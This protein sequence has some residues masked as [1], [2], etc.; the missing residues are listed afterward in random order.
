MRFLEYT[1][2]YLWLHKC[3]EFIHFSNDAHE[4]IHGSIN[5]HEFIHGSLH[6]HEF[7]HGSMDVHSCSVVI[8]DHIDF[9]LLQTTPINDKNC[10]GN[11][12]SLDVR[13]DKS[14]VHEGRCQLD[15]KVNRAIN[16]LT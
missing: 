9:E 11:Y 7:I 4:F 8:L 16:P 5:V 10:K 2:F 3:N 15:K 6:V 14:C 1:L 13:G 12:S